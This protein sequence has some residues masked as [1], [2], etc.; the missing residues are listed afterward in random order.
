MRHVRQADPR[1]R[2][3]VDRDAGEPG[4]EREGRRHQGDRRRGRRRDRLRH[5]RD[6]RRHKAGWRRHPRRHQRG[7]Q[8]PDRHRQDLDE[9]GRRPG[10]HRL[11]ARRSTARRSWR[12][13]A[14][15]RRDHHGAAS[16]RS[17]STAGSAGSGSRSR[18]SSWPSSPSRFFALPFIGL[19]WKAP[20]GDVWSILTSRQ[21]AHRAAPV[22]V[23]LD[24]GDGP[25]GR[26]S[27][28]RS[29]GCWP[30]SS[31]PGRGLVRALCTL[32]MV[33]P[34]VVAGVALFYALG[35]RGLVG[36]YLDRWFGITLPFTTG[37]RDRRPD[38]R[39]HAVPR[40]HRRG[41]VP[42]ARHPLRG[43]GPHARRRPAGTSFRRVTLPAIRPGLV[44]GAVL[45][46][47]RALG[48]FGATITFAGNFPG[49]TQTMPLAIYLANETNPDEAIVLS[50]VLIAVSFA[51]LVALRDR[52]LGGG[53]PAGMTLSTP[54][55]CGRLGTFAARRRARRQDRARSSPCSGRTARA[56]PRCS[57]AW[58]GCCPID[59]GRI[60]L[61]GECLDDPAADVFVPPGAPSGRRGVPGL[62]AVR[63]PHRARERRLRAARPRRR[64]GRGP[65][66]G[67]GR[68]WSASASPTTPATDPGPCPGARRSG[69]PWPGR[70]PPS[71]A[72]CCST[73]RWPPSTPAPAATCA[74]TCAATSATFDG[75]RLLVTHDP[76]DAYAL[77]DRVVILEGGRVVQTGT[78][79]DVTAQPRSRYIADL[80]GIN[81]L[82][83]DGRRRRH[84]HRDRRAHRARRPG[85][86]A[87]PSP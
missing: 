45:A 62:P 77:A 59:D 14:S 4:A 48:E 2:A 37:G 55:W 11:P 84:H 19:L 13:T 33:L 5:R 80:V 56:R 81:L 36:Q 35:R 65:G 17:P 21:L 64:Q 78:L 73:S 67:G 24:V 83:G 20:W 47:A 22:A 53:T 72:C 87:R 16:G 75:V 38:L 7:R 69:S 60:E 82:A 51:V 42:P 6:G 18:P 12:S 58:P 31:F 40:D 71:R 28:S 79:A 30:G 57:A 8:V 70:W 23:L 15:A 46:W 25:G 3:G 85:A 74:A 66:A 63:Q 10:L 34:P 44:A 1:Q 52:F 26:C 43:G 68:G 41:G 32:S 49:R 54:A 29:P 9:P 50:L 39:G 76:V 61:D 86:T 27:A